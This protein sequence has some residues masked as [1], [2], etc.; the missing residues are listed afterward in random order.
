[1]TEPSDASTLAAQTFLQAQ[2][3]EGPIAASL[4]RQI[5][6]EVTAIVPEGKK[7]AV[8]GVAT[9]DG[10]RLT[11]AVRLGDAGHF[12]LSGDV[13]ET[14]GGKVSGRVAVLATF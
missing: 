10:W 11:G 13:G 2:V 9:Q 4:R 6:S 7:V 1:M 8:L 5:E 3:P 12:Q 14:W